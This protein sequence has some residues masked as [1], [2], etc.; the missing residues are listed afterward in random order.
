MVLPCA[1]IWSPSHLC[2]MLPCGAGAT[3]ARLLLAA[4]EMLH[5]L[6]ACQ[7]QLGSP[8]ARCDSGSIH[9]LWVCWGLPGSRGCFESLFSCTRGWEEVVLAYVDTNLLLSVFP[10]L[11]TKTSS[12]QMS[13][14]AAPPPPPPVP[15][16][17]RKNKA[18]M[19]KP[20]MQNRGV[21]CKIEM[22]SKGCQTGR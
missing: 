18:A 15:A 3:S 6:A 16:T 12:A 21:S 11:S 2:S 5:R 17:P 22:K 8:L 9:V 1:W 19:C 14:A 10:Q 4:A 7:E 20:L 13:P